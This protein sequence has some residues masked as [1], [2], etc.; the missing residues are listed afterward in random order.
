LLI[1][2]SLPIIDAMDCDPRDRDD[3]ARDVEMPWVDVRRFAVD[4]ESDDPRNREDDTRDRDGDARE[5]DDPRDPFVNGL[6]LP[7]GPERELV[8]DG[9][10]RY[11]LNGDDSRTLATVGAFRVVA[12]RDLSDPREESE[13]VRAAGLRHL[14]DEGLTQSVKLEGRERAV[15]LT[16]RGRHL[17]ETHRRDREDGREQAFYAGVTRPRELSHD[18]QVYRAYLREE[19]RLREQGADVRRVA[20]ES[21]LKREYQE[22]LQASNRGRPDSDGRPD[23]DERE[24]ERWAHDHDLPYFDDQVHFP[25]VRIEYEIRGRAEHED[26]EVVTAHYRG[27]HAASVARSGFRCY[28]CAGRTGRTGGRGFDPRVAEDVLC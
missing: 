26:V 12:E 20:L 23:R 6:E 17:L 3:D 22:W 9:D 21:E 11:E 19:E 14:R 24:I 25:D 8:F 2:P 28:G 10:H 4:A 15:T 18:V 7:R 1:D 27:A 16:D 5:R 13:N